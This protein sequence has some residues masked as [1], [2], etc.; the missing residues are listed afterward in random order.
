M[1]HGGPSDLLYGQLYH[2]DG[3]KL[4]LGN[5]YVLAGLI[6]FGSMIAAAVLA[7]PSRA[8]LQ[9]G[10]WLTGP[11]PGVHHDRPTHVAS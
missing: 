9:P 11:L 2:W 4:I 5:A 1:V 7:R 3:A 8:L 10:R 6:L